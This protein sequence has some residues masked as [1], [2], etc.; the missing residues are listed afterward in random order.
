M[1]EDDR[2]VT[3]AEIEALIESVDEKLPWWAR[4]PRTHAQFA[5]A[6]ILRTPATPVYDDEG[7]L[8]AYRGIA[9]K[10]HREK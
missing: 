4:N 9:L 6:L 8:V 2:A 7:V 5:A 1:I 10:K 3:R